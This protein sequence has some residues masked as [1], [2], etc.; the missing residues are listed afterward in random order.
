MRRLPGRV[1]CS[2]QLHAWRPP[3]SWI[4]FKN[5][6]GGKTVKGLS[7]CARP[8]CRA[9]RDYIK[10]WSPKVEKVGPPRPLR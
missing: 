5:N 6:D 1:L 2:L 3:T 7:K 4:T 9:V 8:D 10:S